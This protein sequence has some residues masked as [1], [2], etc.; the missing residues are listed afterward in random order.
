M[1]VKTDPSAREMLDVIKRLESA[2][3]M[4]NQNQSKLI[5]NEISLNATQNNLLTNKETERLDA[6]VKDNKKDIK[7]LQQQTKLRHTTLMIHAWLDLLQSNAKTAEI[8]QLEIPLQGWTVKTRL[9]IINLLTR[10]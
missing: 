8:V 9:S 7:E 3:G 4:T 10:A 5:E 6:V 2:I 1:G